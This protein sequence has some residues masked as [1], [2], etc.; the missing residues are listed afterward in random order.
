M[1]ALDDL[2]TFARSFRRNLWRQSGKFHRTRLLVTGQYVLTSKR[3]A[4]P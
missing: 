1:T 3:K 2:N 4:R